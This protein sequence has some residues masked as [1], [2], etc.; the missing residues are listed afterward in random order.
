[1]SFDL[2]TG[3]RLLL[4]GAQF[5]WFWLG[6]G[7]LA[8]ILLAVLYRA[9]RRLVSRRAGLGL[10]GL[11]LLA[12]FALVAALF[13]PIAARV[14]RETLRGR[15][16]VAVDVSRSMETTDPGRTD[17]ERAALG[18]TLALAPGER[19]DSM[20]RREV[21]RRLLD[22]P[23]APVAR[24]SA[25]HA[26]DVMSF[27]RT[28]AP[29]TVEALGVSLRSPG[30]ADDPS[31]RETDWQPALA[32]ALRAG[33]GAAPVLG[34]VLLTDGRQNA[35]PSEQAATVLD[36]LASGGVAVFPILIGS[37]VPP[38][39]AAIATVRA[40]ETVYRGDSATIQA[41][42]KV[43]GVPGREVAVTLDRPGGSPIRQLVRAPMDASAP[44]PTVSFKVP[45]EEP[46]TTALTLAV[47]PL[48][49][50]IRPD[51][52]RRTVTIQVVDDRA[53]VLLIEGE[54]RW[55]F[56]YLR[57]ALARDPHVTVKAV[58]LHPPSA[59][60]YAR[61]TFET[62]LPTRGP[63]PEKQP[64]PLGR[65]EAIILGDV[66]PSDLPPAEW[67]RLEWFV[68]ER[69]GTLILGPGPRSWAA[70]A[71]Q[72]TIRRLLPITGAEPVAIAPTEIDPSR[73]ALVP[74]VALVPTAAALDAADWP[75]FSLASEPSQNRSTW[76]GLPRLPWV[77]AGRA[78]PGATTLATAG[79]GE[80]T[81]AIAAQ[82]YGLGKV[83][84][85][86]TDGTWRWRHRV[87]DAYH[88]RFWGQ[89]VRWAAARKPAAGNRHVR[90]GPLRPRVAEGEAARIQARI[91]EDLPDVGPDLLIA[92]R[93]YRLDPATRRA[94]GEPVALVPLSS[95]PGRPRTFEATAPALP[96]GAYMIRLDVPQ[97]AAA[98]GLDADREGRPI[99]EARLDVVERETSE[100]VELAAARDPLDR[101]AAA[102]GGR[103]LADHEAGQLA[104]L[105]HARTRTVIRTEETPLWDQP[106][107]LLFFFGLLTV[108]WVA[109]KRLGL[110]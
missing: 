67:A 86:G 13:E 82:P 88:H 76:D 11:R 17:A 75:M 104:P 87:G 16:V 20:P 29:A 4:A 28:T 89:V 12:A 91:A 80:A 77:V 5:G 23:E 68:A 50:D 8:V 105:L 109:R 31:T 39:D 46:G 108:E 69:G 45:M 70:L 55:E 101:L 34:V 47:G 99:P 83:L 107:A 102:T 85:V 42:V 3:R 106:A 24:L 37:T 64:D 10:L 58:V 22:R 40:P 48:D 53:D 33:A 78:K 54:S 84:W 96:A 110:P 73:P 25:E 32:E 56:R 92:A 71:G 97:L 26:L 49:G 59:A 103:V 57:N 43:D 62:A 35:A 100:L 60:G 38:R 95:V 9:E 1:M 98:L 18:R 2:A 36:R 27:A 65:F 94:A 72:E 15:V 90:F 19:V 6:A 61:P 21:A 7:A 52:D 41:S 51:N 30:K 79:S 63:S 44:R 93:V 74:G 14:Y 81:A 66:S